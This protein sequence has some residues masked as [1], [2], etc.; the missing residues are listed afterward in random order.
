MIP[1]FSGQQI[2][3]ADYYAINK[4]GIPSIVL[5]EN[6]ARSIHSSLLEFLPH[7]SD[8]KKIGIICGKGN[9]GGDGFALAR[10]L[11]ADGFD[12]SVIS[13]GAEDELKGDALINFTILKNYTELYDN[14]EIIVYSS[15]KDLVS[16]ENC[17]VIV[18]AMLGTGSR[19]NLSEPYREI[20][21]KLNTLDSVKVAVDLPTGLDIET[22]SGDLIFDAD[23]TVTLAEFKTGLFYE[24]GYSHC[25]AIV[26]GSIGM[27][28]EYF[29]KLDTNKYLIEPE[30]A[31]VGIP[32]KKL[33]LHK[34]SAGKV[35]TIAGSKSYTGAA[36]YTSNSVIRSG[37]GA[38]ILAIPRSIRNL[39]QPL[40]N[41]TVVLD[42]EDNENGF[43]SNS[44]LKE[45]EERINWADVLV[46]GPGLGRAD[47][48][49]GMVAEII[50][51]HKSK[52][53]VI[54]ADGLCALQNEEYKKMNLKNKI[55]TPHHKE[56]ADIIG[57]SVEELEL[58]LIN[59]GAEFAKSTG[60][61][62]VLKGA[63]SL[64][65]SPYDEVFINSSGNPG[66]AKY[67][68]GDVLTGIIGSFISQS[69]EIENSLISALYLH[70]LTADL[71]AENLTEYS[72]TPEDLINGFPE[73]LKFILQSFS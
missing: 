48:T 68:S 13:L 53:M 37:T 59:I 43:F 69:K 2:R 38:S 20:V 70:S 47:E 71:L 9:N 54:D 25:G 32:L 45:L 49:I 65:F 30:D 55:L 31:F 10:L 3:E 27:G 6:A 1:L 72:L 28:D 29:T 5:M 12:V 46:I 50:K 60:C 62:L 73:T 44:N 39:V 51:S 33:D 61:Y 8:I 7:N 64:I 19:G 41:A 66:L 56:F 17:D 26:K 23:L 18:D 15:T 21:E 11:V 35:L 4:L 52:I 36:V 40:L 16:I 58:D 14:L 34:Y 67:G 63:P 22:S 24:K 42:C 57:V